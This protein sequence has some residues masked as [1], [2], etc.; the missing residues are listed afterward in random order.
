MDGN[1]DNLQNKRRIS[2]CIA[3]KRRLHAATREKKTISVLLSAE[4]AR[5]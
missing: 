1:N 5:R 4:N 3:P 2:G